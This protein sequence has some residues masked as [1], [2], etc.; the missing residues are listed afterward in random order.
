MKVQLY[1]LINYFTF[2]DIYDKKPIH[3]RIFYLESMKIKI[4]SPVEKQLKITFIRQ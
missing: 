4:S 3:I 1:L 2:T